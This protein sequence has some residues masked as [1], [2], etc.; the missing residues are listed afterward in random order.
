MSLPVPK[1]AELKG[2]HHDAWLIIILYNYFKEVVPL[3]RLLC[4]HP[5]EPADS[6]HFVTG[7]KTAP[8]ADNYL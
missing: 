3:N 4:I 5:K 2:V 8:M 6:L 7:I 1:S